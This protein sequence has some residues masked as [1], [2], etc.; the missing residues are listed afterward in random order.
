MQVSIECEAPKCVEYPYVGKYAN[1]G[2]TIV[3]MFTGHKKGVCLYD[4]FCKG[5]NTRVG[6]VKDTWAEEKYTPTK[7]T[8]DS[9][10]GK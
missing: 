4:T 1:H 8:L 2:D 6:M 9:I 10:G 7:I 3:V 5:I